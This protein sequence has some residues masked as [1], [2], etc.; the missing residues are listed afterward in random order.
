[1]DYEVAGIPVPFRCL[2]DKKMKNLHLIFTLITD[3]NI[4]SWSSP[5]RG[6]WLE[7][8]TDGRRYGPDYVD[9]PG[10]LG[11]SWWTQFDP[12]TP[13]EDSRRVG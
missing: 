7:T 2:D 10:H 8:R 4:G 11:G 9:V 13:R 5:S 6:F 1:M 3:H 12:L